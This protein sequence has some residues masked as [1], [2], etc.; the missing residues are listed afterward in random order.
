MT[1][2]ATFSCVAVGAAMGFLL[3]ML[4]MAALVTIFP[5]QG[6]WPAAAPVEAATAAEHQV[7]ATPAPSVNVTDDLRQRELVLLVQGVRRDDLR[8]TFN[9]ARGGARR[10]EAL[11]IPATR[12]TPVLAV[13]N[14]TIAKLFLSEPGGITIYQFDPSKAYCYYY[15]HLEGYAAGLKEGQTVARGEVIGYV[16]TTGNAPKD[17]PHLH[18]AIFKLADDKRWWHGTPIDPYSVLK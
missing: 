14:G 9:E 13:E 3:G 16:G 17:V 18:F 15:A 7:A 6:M 4:V 1:Q 10:H 12:H 2:R 8:D 11:D 5:A